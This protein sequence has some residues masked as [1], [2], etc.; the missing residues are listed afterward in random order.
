MRRTTRGHP[1]RIRRAT[2]HPRTNIATYR[3]GPGRQWR[4]RPSAWRETK[5]LKGL[6][7]KAVGP[8]FVCVRRLFPTRLTVCAQAPSQ[9]ARR[10]TTRDGTVIA[11][12]IGA[13]G[14]AILASRSTII[15]TFRSRSLRACA[16]FRLSYTSRLRRAALNRCPIL[17]MPTVCNWRR[18][19]FSTRRF[20]FPASFCK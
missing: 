13:S 11:E 20:F 1:R 16:R 5:R 9:S 6:T 17:P 7:L 4:S 2:I 15:C 14:I 8:F 19:V 3:T 10:T 18:G 12:L